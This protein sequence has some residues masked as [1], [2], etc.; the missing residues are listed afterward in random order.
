MNETKLEEK[1]TAIDPF[2]YK[3]LLKQWNRPELHDKLIKMCDVLADEY[4][5]EYNVDR[6][7]HGSLSGTQTSSG[8]NIFYMEKRFPFIKDFEKMV[9]QMVY[10][11]FK[12]NPNFLVPTSYE[13]HGWFNK[14]DGESEHFPHAHGDVDLVIN[15]YLTTP[16]GQD[17]HT[18]DRKIPSRVCFLAPIHLSN[19]RTY[20]REK[21]TAQFACKPMEMLASPPCYL[22]YVPRT[23][24]KEWR[25]SISINI[26]GLTYNTKL[27]E[28]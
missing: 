28:Y 25:R 4:N 11:F 7:G 6:G 16:E 13:I 26:V 23:H 27:E 24:S 19:C 14:F 8:K 5:G 20:M 1:L 10:D 15:Y 21:N 3:F 17:P 9:K 18:P 12:A 2:M 22:H